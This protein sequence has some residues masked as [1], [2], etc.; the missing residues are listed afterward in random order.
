MIILTL[1]PLGEGY[2][3]VLV[4]VDTVSSLT[5]DFPCCHANQAAIIRGL[6]KLSTMYKYSNQ[7]DGDQGHISKVMIYKT[8]QS[9][10][11]IEILPQHFL[12]CFPD[13]LE[14]GGRG[15]EK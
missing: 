8:G 10:L 11:T 3:Y 9:S 7:I 15:Q 5:Q 1:F 4:C 14:E 2:K 12:P 6:E 13:G